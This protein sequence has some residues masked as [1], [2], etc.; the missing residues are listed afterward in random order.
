MKGVEYYSF[1]E[2]IAFYSDMG[3]GAIASGERVWEAIA[4]CSDMDRGAI[5]LLPMIVLNFIP[6]SQLRYQELTNA[7]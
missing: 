2:A 5:N 1:W 4:F 6:K 7:N 3:R